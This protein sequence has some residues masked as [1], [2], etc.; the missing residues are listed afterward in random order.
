M[1][2]LFGTERVCSSV[3]TMVCRLIYIRHLA[4]T[5][6]TDFRSGGSGA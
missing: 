5:N 2:T 6:K 4:F 1:P 3:T